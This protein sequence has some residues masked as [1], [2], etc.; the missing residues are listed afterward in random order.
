MDFEKSSEPLVV[1]TEAIP[2][3]FITKVEIIFKKLDVGDKEISFVCGSGLTS[4]ILLLASEIAQ[5]NKT[6]V[7]DGSWTEWGSSE[8]LPIEKSKVN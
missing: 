5:S 7:Y 6:S 2:S 3:L 4:C 1:S 8:G